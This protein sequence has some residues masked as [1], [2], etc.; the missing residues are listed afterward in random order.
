M[1]LN[2]LIESTQLTHEL[3]KHTRLLDGDRYLVISKGST[4]PKIVEL[5][6]GLRGR[7]KVVKQLRLDQMLE[8]L[9]S[10][11]IEFYRAVGSRRIYR[12]VGAK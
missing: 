10:G 1:K 11:Y 3:K 6:N 9:D 5:P 8:L 12:L 7:K 4:V 2:D